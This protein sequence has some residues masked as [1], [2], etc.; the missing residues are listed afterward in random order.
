[1]PCDLIF[2]Y[3]LLSRNDGNAHSAILADERINFIAFTFRGKLQAYGS[4]ASVEIQEI[5]DMDSCYSLAVSPSHCVVS[6][7]YHSD[8][9]ELSHKPIAGLKPKSDPEQIN[10][11]VANH[12]S[13]WIADSSAGRVW[14]F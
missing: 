11:P 1:V 4:K 10:E 3:V 12:A 8:L 7:T 13:A 14:F 9:I 6:R 2:C 5:K